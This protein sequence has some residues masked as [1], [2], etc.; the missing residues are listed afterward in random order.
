MSKKRSPESEEYLEAL[1][2]Y[3]EVGKNPKVKELA[4]DLGVSSAS[5]SEMLKKLSKKGLVKYER[6]GE[7][8]LTKKGTSLGKKVLRKHRL[9]ER[10]LEFI[11]VKKTK[12]HK[13]ACVLEHALSD[14]VETALRGVMSTSSTGARRRLCDLLRGDSGTIISIEGGKASSRRLIDLGLTPGTKVTVARA[15][16]RAGPVELHVRSSCL[17]IGR[18]LAR[19]I[20]VEVKK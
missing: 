9:I 5:V 15:S 10:F 14:D 18:G 7:A 3:Q 4:K 13:E 17:A 2:R 6:Y 19:K 11:G 12:I 1:V 16:S 20:F 8:Q